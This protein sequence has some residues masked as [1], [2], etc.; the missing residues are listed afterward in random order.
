MFIIM[1]RFSP[2]S[3]NNV[4]VPCSNVLHRSSVA[5]PNR[6]DVKQERA[7]QY[8][9][10]NELSTACSSIETLKSTS[11]QSVKYTN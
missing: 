6:F 10:R 8:V 2:S 4:Y 1:L 9:K 7:S 3:E 5:K 11:D